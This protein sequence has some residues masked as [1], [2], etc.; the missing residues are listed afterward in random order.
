MLILGLAG[1]VVWLRERRWVAEARLCLAIFAW[2]FLVNMSFNGYHAGFSAG[3]RYLVPGMPFLALP[4]VVAFARWQRTS[5]LMVALFGAIAVGILGA[6]TLFRF[7]SGSFGFGIVSAWVVVGVGILILVFKPQRTPVFLLAL[8][9]LQQLL[10]TATDGQNPLAVGGHARLPDSHRK[11]DFFCN[12]VTEYAAPLFFIGRC[13]GLLDQLLEARLD[14]EAE[15]LKEANDDP[16]EVQR[17]RWPPAHRI[18]EE[19][20]PQRTAAFV[21]APRSTGRFR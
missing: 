21:L 12:L 3:P 16:A 15:Q 5:A 2:F 6:E 8:S 20:R 11:D 13:E 9:I 17:A 19:H 18:A 7:Q 14:G 10:L 4:L 1:L